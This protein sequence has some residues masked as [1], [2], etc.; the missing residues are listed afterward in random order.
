MSCSVAHQAVYPAFPVSAGSRWSQG[1]AED[2]VWVLQEGPVQMCM[3]WGFGGG[4]P[5]HGAGGEGG[6][7]RDCSLLWEYSEQ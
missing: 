3:P 1:N 2:V 4:L 6:V 5:E 7:L